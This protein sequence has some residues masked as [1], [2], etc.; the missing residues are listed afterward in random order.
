MFTLL[1]NRHSATI[2]TDSAC[3]DP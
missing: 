1:T 3:I 2:C